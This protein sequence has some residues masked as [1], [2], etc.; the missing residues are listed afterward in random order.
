MKCN[1][2]RWLWGLVALLP[3]AILA[4]LSSRSAIEADLKARVEDNLKRANLGWAEVVM[5]GRNALI[6]GKAQEDGDPDKALKI[7]NDIWGVRETTNS[8]TLIDKVE[9]YEWT[10][11]RRDNKIR[12]NGFV[13]SEKTRLDVLGMVKGTF[14]GQQ[15]EDHMKLARGAPPLDIWLGGVSFGLKQLAQLKSGQVDLA[16][17]NLTVT[18]EANDVAGYRGVRTALA[19]SLPKGVKLAKE[20]IRPPLVKPYSWAA[21]SAGNSILLSGY[22]PNDQVREQIVSAAKRASP[23]AQIV[24]EMQP[25]DGAP[26]GF[27]QA[28]TAVL[29]HFADIDEARADLRDG[30][31]TISGITESA[32]RSDGIRG[33]LKKA[34]PASFKMADQIRHREPQIRTIS[35]YQTA[36]QI[37]GGTVLLTGHVPSEEARQSLLGMARQHFK[38]RT[39]QDRTE[40]GAGQIAG[41]QR[42]L[43]TGM[44]ALERLGN[45]RTVL[46]DRRLEVTAAT[47]VEALAQGLPGDVRTTAGRDCDPDVRLTFNPRPDAGRAEAEAARLKAEADAR[48]RAKADAEARAKADEEARSKAAAAVAVTARQQ[49]ASSCQDTLRTV[50]REGLINFKRASAEIEPASFAT[51]NKLAEVAGTCPNVAIDVEGHTDAEGTP[52]RNQALSDRRARSVTDYLVRAGVVSS[53][54]NPIGYGQS[55]NIAANDTP[56][57]RAKN[58]RIEFSVK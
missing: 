12:I 35:P 43:D 45:G 48:A 20:A 26:D 41:W 39:V 44:T 22:V 24:D 7:A 16:Q 33:A 4:V 40:I 19:S 38:G 42:C 5:D 34:I 13:P 52:E 55:R 32:A 3:L 36:V 58:R 54:L 23:K 25:A 30:A 8:A 53:R 51:L 17:T 47:D 31:V 46:L 6:Q 21:K 56:E 28:I 37:D 15:V 10:A 14:P 27:A 2:L 1:P 29:G 18:G 50:M 11:L 9:K 49:Q 57:N